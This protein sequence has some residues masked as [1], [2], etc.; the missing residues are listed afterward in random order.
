MNALRDGPM[1]PHR[2]Y[3][4]EPTATVTT[5]TDLHVSN[6]AETEGREGAPG[7]Q[8]LVFLL[9]VVVGGETRPR[10]RDQG[11]Q[12]DS[13][14]SHLEEFGENLE[15]RRDVTHGIKLLNTWTRCVQ[16]QLL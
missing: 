5:K 14:P 1:V 4:D 7:Q 2:F 13:T 10:R 8:P 6:R 11:P 3:S 16:V 12:R 9:H 15:R